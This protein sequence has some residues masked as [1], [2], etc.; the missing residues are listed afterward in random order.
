MP[1]YEYE[2]DK[3]GKRFE[4]L[5]SMD[6]R[7]EVEC[8]DCKGAVHIRIS[9]IGKPIEAH[10]FMVIGHDGTVLSQRQTTETTPLK[11]I[12][13]DGREINHKLRR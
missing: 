7:H 10:T 6:R 13:R 9:T 8:P 1:I 12:T 11:V 5:R 4:E 3:C 2:C